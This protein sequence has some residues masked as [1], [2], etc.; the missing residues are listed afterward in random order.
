MSEKWSHIIESGSNLY[1]NDAVG[2]FYICM[3]SWDLALQLR[4]WSRLEEILLC[5]LKD[6]ANALILLY[7]CQAELCLVKEYL[8]KKGYL[9]CNIPK[10]AFLVIL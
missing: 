7:M 5:Y 6:V 9:I 3:A 8:I 1:Q 2:D 4:S 10:S